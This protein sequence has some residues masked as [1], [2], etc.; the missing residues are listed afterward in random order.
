MKHDNQSNLERKELHWLTLPNYCPSFKESRAGT[1]T[2]Q[3][4]GS[5]SCWKQK[6]WKSATYHLA[7]HDFL[8]LLSYRTH[9]HQLRDGTT[10]NKLCLPHQRRNY[11]AAR[12]YGSIFSTEVP[13]IRN[14][15]GCV[16]S[17]CK[18]SQHRDENVQVAHW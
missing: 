16:W 2:E 6:L 15:L 5:R 10:H 7:S 11:L 3:E 4:A 12:T 13:S 9:H 8:S 1:Q 17:L 18:T 14:A